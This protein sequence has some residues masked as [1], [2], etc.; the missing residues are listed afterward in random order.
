MLFLP[1]SP[2]YV[3]THLHGCMPT[4]L[5]GVAVPV[6]RLGL[7]EEGGLGDDVAGEGAGMHQLP[8]YPR[9]GVWG[10]EEE[11]RDG[12]WVDEAGE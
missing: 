7:A 8:Q 4:H 10:D 1:S 6:L 12:G 2:T 9:L 5:Y 3:L 11:G